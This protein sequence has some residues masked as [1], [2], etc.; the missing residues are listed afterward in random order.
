MLLDEFVARIGVRIETEALV[1]I[2]R[3][4]F[5]PAVPLFRIVRE[6]KWK[7]NFAFHAYS[8]FNAPKPVVACSMSS[9]AKPVFRSIDNSVRFPAAST[10]TSST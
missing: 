6:W 3:L 10:A 5:G 7:S 9:R 2:G 1:K 4:I 8:T